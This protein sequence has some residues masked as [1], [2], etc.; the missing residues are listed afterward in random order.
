MLYLDTS[1]LLKLFLNEPES[2]AVRRG[3][4]RESAVVISSLAELEAE[5]QLRA[6]YLGG[7]FKAA[8]WRAY[9][10]KLGELRDLEPFSF[11]DL[12]GSVFTTALR[13]HREAGK[14]HCRTLDRLHL[15]AMEELGCNRLMTHDDAQANAAAALGHSVLRPGRS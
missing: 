11:R 3:V 15:A 13:Q 4:A 9:R 14:G 8:Q 12:A 1:C 2:A 10:R 6:G 5:V 7:V